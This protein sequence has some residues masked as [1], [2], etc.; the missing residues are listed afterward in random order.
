MILHAKFVLVD[1]ADV[2]G[3][4][5]GFKHQRSGIG[6]RL[7]LPLYLGRRRRDQAGMTASPLVWVRHMNLRSEASNGLR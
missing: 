3:A 5:T 4:L 7:R 1:V 6:R 2:L